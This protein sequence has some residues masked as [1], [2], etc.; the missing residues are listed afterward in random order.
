MMNWM[1]R[2]EIKGTGSETD[3]DRSV[4]ISVVIH[5]L[6]EPA[7]RNTITPQYESGTDRVC[8]KATSKCHT[9]TQKK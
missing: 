7:L 1:N 8:V 3:T 9:D 6:R 4:Q 5:V 2:T